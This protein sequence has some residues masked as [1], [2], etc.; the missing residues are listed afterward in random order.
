MEL[1]A[2]TSD[3]TWGKNILKLKIPT[4]HQSFHPKPKFGM[5]KLLCVP[6]VICANLK[7][8]SFNTKLAHTWS[9]FVV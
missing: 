7:E 2:S 3:V 5:S 6:T 9:T 1:G 8:N 4:F